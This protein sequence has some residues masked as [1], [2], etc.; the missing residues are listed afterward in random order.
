MRSPAE[1]RTVPTK[2]I[3]FEKIHVLLQTDPVPSR[4]SELL[5]DAESLLAS[6]LDISA[7]GVPTEGISELWRLIFRT[8][9]QRLPAS[10][11]TPSSLGIAASSL[12]K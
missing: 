4:E 11:V 2:T 12:G 6:D 1:S 3:V 8:A 7:V 10:S 9:I 5:T